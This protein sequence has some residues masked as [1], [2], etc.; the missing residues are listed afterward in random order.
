MSITSKIK[1]LLA[2][3]GFLL[4]AMLFSQAAD[5]VIPPVGSPVFI[6]D[7]KVRSAPN[8]QWKFK[9][10]DGFGFYDGSILHDG[11]R[12]KF[13]LTAKFDNSNQ[14]VSS[15]QLSISGAIPSLGINDKNTTLLTADLT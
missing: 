14:L 10:K 13:S 15:T 4:A 1:G 9:G 3:M 7:I 12:G 11:F 6:N 2:P 8:G 5:A